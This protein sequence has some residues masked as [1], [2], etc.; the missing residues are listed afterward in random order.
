MP[1][2]FQLNFLSFLPTVL[3]LGDLCEAVQHADIHYLFCWLKYLFD[4]I[5]K[6]SELTLLLIQIRD[7]NVTQSTCGR[8]QSLCVRMTVVL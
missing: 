2:N 6:S 4:K 5:Q 8:S 3:K 7:Y 1:N